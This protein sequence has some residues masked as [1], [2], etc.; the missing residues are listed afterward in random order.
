MRRTVLPFVGSGARPLVARPAAPEPTIAFEHAIRAEAPASSTP[1]HVAVLGPAGVRGAEDGREVVKDPVDRHAI[2]AIPAVPAPSTR[3]LV[4]A[5]AR[6]GP[7]NLVP[8]RSARP[9]PAPAVDAIVDGGCSSVHQGTI[10]TIVHGKVLGDL[11]G[12]I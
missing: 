12:T 7:S 3:R 6:G 10:P 1:C 8:A 2:Y 5:G 4:A 11:W 9:A